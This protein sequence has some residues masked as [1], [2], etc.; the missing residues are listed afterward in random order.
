[1]EKPSDLLRRF[2]DVLDVITHFGRLK[3]SVA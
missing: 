2:S 3:N 1:M